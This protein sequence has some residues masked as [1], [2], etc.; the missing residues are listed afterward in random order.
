MTLFDQAHFHGNTFFNEADFK[1]IVSLDGAIFHGDI[2]FNN[3]TFC[4]TTAVG[5]QFLS[6]SKESIEAIKFLKKIDANFDGAV[7]NISFSNELVED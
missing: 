7:F 3:T 5:A 6:L 1:K 4:E 2:F